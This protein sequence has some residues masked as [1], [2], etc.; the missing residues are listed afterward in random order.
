MFNIRIQELYVQEDGEHICACQTSEVLL[1][2][3]F[4]A[5]ISLLLKK[6]HVYTICMF[7]QTFQDVT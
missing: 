1:R 2:N 3:C 6:K 4:I 5:L 7:T